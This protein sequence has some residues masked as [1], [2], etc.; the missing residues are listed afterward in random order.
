MAGRSVGDPKEP[1][2]R[3]AWSRDVTTETWS[4]RELRHGQAELEVGL[5]AMLS[6]VRTALAK[7]P[8]AGYIKP[9]PVEWG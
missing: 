8:R 2:P 1:V 9:V 5:R 3:Y 7:S 6:L 4:D